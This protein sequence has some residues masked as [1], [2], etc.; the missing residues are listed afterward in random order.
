MMRARVLVCSCIN[1]FFF[2]NSWR[3]YHPTTGTWVTPK[4]SKYDVIVVGGGHNGLVS[5]AYL[6]KQG[7]NVLVRGIVCVI[8]LTPT[9]LFNTVTFIPFSLTKAPFSRLVYVVASIC[10]ANRKRCDCSF[11][12]THLLRSFHFLSSLPE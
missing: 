2:P 9:Y 4:E 1:P 3:G 11:C 7:L 10:V 6:G 5:A 8:Q 12:D